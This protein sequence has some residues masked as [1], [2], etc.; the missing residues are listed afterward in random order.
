MKIST[1][2]RLFWLIVGA[3]VFTLPA[4]AE[5]GN[6]DHPIL[7]EIYQE[8]SVP[9]GPATTD[10]TNPNTPHQE[11]IEIFIP[12]L[13]DLSPTLDKDALNLTFY[14]IEGDASSPGLSQVNLRVDL[15]TFDLDPSNGL[16]GL[17][18]PQTGIVVLGWI[19]YLG[20]PPTGLT[21]TPNS[22]TAMINGGITGAAG[23][24]FIPLNG[25]Q[26]EGTYNFPLPV[27]VSYIDTLSDPLTG[28]VEQ[29]S[30]AYLLVNRDDPGYSEL[31]G[32]T[33]PATCDSFPNL[34]SGSKL[35]L[36]CLL[37]AFAANDDASFNLDQQPYLAPS[38]D[39]IDL[40][41]VLP[42]G[43]AFSVWVPQ[44]P[45]EGSGY[46]RILV[47]R[48]KTSE[49]GIP[50]N[51][52][53]ALDA[54]TAYRS[55][56][57]TGPFFA[58]PGYAASSTS[59]G[60][61]SVAITPLQFFQVL[62]ETQARPGLIA[63]NIGG[64]FGIQT[65]STPGPTRD[66]SAMNA[67]V[68]QSLSLPIA[69]SAIAPY[70][71]VETFATTP[72]GHSEFITIELDSTTPVPGNPPTTDPLHR[73]A[74]YLVT[75]DPTT[76]QDAQGQS[77]QGTALFALQGVPVMEGVLNP[78][79]ETSLGSGMRNNSA[80]FP[81][82]RGNGASLSD[83]SSDLSD[84]ALIQPM[85][86]TMPTDPTLFINPLGAG[87]NLVDVVLNSAEVVSGASSYANSFN[88]S[89][90]LVQAREFN[91]V[92]T[93]TTGGFTPTERIH[94]A[95]AKGAAGKL[96]DGL[97]DVVTKRD[98]EVALIDSQLSPVGTLE[99][100][101]T[102]DFGVAVRVEQVAPG[103]S[104]SVGEIIFLSS[105]GGLEG[106]D[107]D[108]LNVPPYENLLTVTYLDL[109]ALNSVMGVETIDRVY[110]IDG[111]GSG[112]VDIVEIVAL[113]EPGTGLALSL[114]VLLL[115]SLERRKQRENPAQ[116]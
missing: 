18:R 76:G 89:E 52:D 112:E 4:G 44:V 53:P 33:D 14:D 75:I 10:L 61:L 34:A 19:Q 15:P 9:G 90:T 115:A 7:T 95:D 6:P 22:R 13:A 58:T 97:T 49:D 16:T 17:P 106:A 59:P 2:T 62:K 80:N 70:F 35:G 69:Q 64:D 21:G 99:T 25:D 54:A 24:T 8:S 73:R 11:F 74:A 92:G 105:M 107:L 46:Q 81:N 30:S 40:E 28:K 83:P 47:D 63:A 100:G 102:D 27:A 98:F 103:A 45:E 32:L 91:L 111:S 1:Q 114:G 82:S 38:G 65:E 77:F 85:I 78:F 94:Y 79:S 48:M 23:F 50:G 20:N 84:P 96:S 56:S 72:L 67:S 43:G 68:T 66:P 41:F 39:N 42:R 37:D 104:A 29:G 36:S 57:N 101:A 93:P 3:G 86:A 51:E 71:D 55:T 108:T 26:F 87:S 12:P 109:D 113:P 116:P 110:V 88:V 5:A 60:R 31:C